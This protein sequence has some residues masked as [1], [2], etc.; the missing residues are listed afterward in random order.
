MRARRASVVRR[1][2]EREDYRSSM[3]KKQQHCKTACFIVYVRSA[4]MD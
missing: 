4:A 2:W 3:A 1:G